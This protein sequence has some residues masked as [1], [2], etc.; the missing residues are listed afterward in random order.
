MEQKIN[1]SNYLN[2]ID[3]EIEQNEAWRLKLESLKIDLNKK[4]EAPRYVFGIDINK[5]FCPIGICGDFGFIIGKAKS[6]KTYLLTLFLANYLKKEKTKKVLYFDTEQG[7]YHAQKSIA[8]LEGV[9]G[10][11]SENIEA[12]QFRKLTPAERLE[13]IE[14]AIYNTP[15]L[16]LVIIDGIR[17]LVNSIN[18]EDEAVMIIGKLMKWTSESNVH[19]IT[20]LHEN[21]GDKNARGW[22]G[23]EALNKAQYVLSVTKDETE[24]NS[25]RVESVAC[26]ETDIEPFAF[27][28]D[29]IGLPQI[30]DGWTKKAPATQKA[31]ITQPH[32][33]GKETY[34]EILRLC[35]EKNDKPRYSELK[36]QLQLAVQKVSGVVLS[37]DRTVKT[38]TYLQNENMIEQRG[39]TG[40]KQSHYVCLI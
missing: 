33:I 22:L 18:S 36:T 29:E 30:L 34:I 38:I 21:K 39:T 11:I 27:Q 1:T 32:E 23:T 24:L 31:K 14:K 20:V 6:R 13:L 15:E 10:F 40:T 37:I 35:F 3:N 28:V 2:Q 8:R 12:Y 16:E 17:D 9:N 25:S 5:V 26:R 4:V 19:I 7:E